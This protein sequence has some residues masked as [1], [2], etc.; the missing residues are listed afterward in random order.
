MGLTSSIRQKCMQCRQWLKRKAKLKKL[1]AH[2][3][4]KNNRQDII[5]ATKV[6]SRA[7]MTGDDGSG[8]EQ[9]IY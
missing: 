4:K 1:S 2:G 6:V 5:L 8:T 9:T 7:P 3:S